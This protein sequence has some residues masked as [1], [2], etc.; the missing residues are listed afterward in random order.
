MLS[1]YIGLIHE[2]VCVRS[3]LVVARISLAR[4]VNRTR[5]VPFYIDDGF[6]WEFDGLCILNIVCIMNFY[7]Y[8][9]WRTYMSKDIL[10]EMDKC[11]Y[12]LYAL[13][14]LS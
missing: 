7:I 3:A 4:G 13:T 8:W 9:V 5:R 1:V 6:K 10:F 11:F 14:I 12:L 2:G